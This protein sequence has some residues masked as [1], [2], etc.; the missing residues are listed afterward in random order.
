MAR[1]EA[2][3]TNQLALLQRQMMEKKRLI[4]E[5]RARKTI[6]S[7]SASVVRAYWDQVTKI[8][9]G[10]EQV[11]AAK[12]FAADVARDIEA[13]QQLRAN[14]ETRREEPE[15]D[16]QLELVK[17]LLTVLAVVLAQ[18]KKRAKELSDARFAWLFSVN[19]AKPKKNPWWKRKEKTQKKSRDKAPSLRELFTPKS[20]EREAP[21]PMEKERAQDKKKDDS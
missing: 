4:S 20:P 11:G 7:A 6:D 12:E 17:S 21:K 3:Q 14:L 10:L 5:I 13:L 2:E 18:T 8:I 19:P 16:S 9:N 1:Y 15:T